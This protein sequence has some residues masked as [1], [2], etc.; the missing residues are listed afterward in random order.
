MKKRWTFQVVLV[1]KNAQASA[2]CEFNLWV[3]KIPYKRRKK[4]LGQV[5]GQGHSLGT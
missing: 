5:P 4:Y 1:V 3:R 2:R